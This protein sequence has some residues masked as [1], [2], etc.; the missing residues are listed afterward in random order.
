MIGVSEVHPAVLEVVMVVALKGR[1]MVLRGVG[2]AT[3][4]CRGGDI[5]CV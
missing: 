2:G 1:E 4:R 5:D 3:N